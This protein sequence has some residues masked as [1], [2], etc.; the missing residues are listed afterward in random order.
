[1]RLPSR[2]DLIALAKAPLNLTV[3]QRLWLGAGIVV[4]VLLVWLAWPRPMNV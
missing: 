1:M 2:T 4:A 3:A